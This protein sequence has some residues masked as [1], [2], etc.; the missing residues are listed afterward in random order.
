MIEHQR[1][2]VG[3]AELRYAEAPGS[4]SPLLLLQ[5]LFGS[6]ETYTPLMPTY[7]DTIFF[8]RHNTVRSL[9][10]Q[11]IASGASMDDLARLM[12]VRPVDEGVTML[13]QKEMG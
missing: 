13:D 5:G 7:R 11:H 2:A 3:D 4:G 8:T 1:A 9:Q 6:L 12:G 10:K